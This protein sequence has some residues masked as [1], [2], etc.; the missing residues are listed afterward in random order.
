M[1]VRH[2]YVALDLV[3]RFDTRYQMAFRCPGASRD[4]TLYGT[5]TIRFRGLAA[6]KS[7]LLVGPNAIYLSGHRGEFGTYI[8]PLLRCVFLNG[9]DKRSTRA[10]GGFMQKV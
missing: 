4:E 3:Q 7:A 2:P 8:I 9:C 6:G 5:S 1:N 10:C